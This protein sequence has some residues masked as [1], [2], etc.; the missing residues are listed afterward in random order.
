MEPF[1]VPHGQALKPALIILTQI[2]PVKWWLYLVCQ[3]SLKIWLKS[4]HSI[5][6][7]RGPHQTYMLFVT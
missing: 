5:I 4:L 1:A 7:N 6:N 3:Y 2:C